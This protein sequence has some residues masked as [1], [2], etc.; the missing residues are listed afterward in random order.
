MTQ[1][2]PLDD[3]PYAAPLAPV[4]PPRGPSEAPPLS[5]LAWRLLA[6]IADYLLMLGLGW[7]LLTPPMI[8]L[9]YGLP[10]PFGTVTA[11]RA[12]GAAVTGPF[13][14]LLWI[15]Y[16]ASQE[17][18][19]RQSTLGKRL[20]RLRVVRVNNEPLSFGRAAYRSVVK[21]VGFVAFWVGCIIALFTPRRQAL[22]DLAAGTAVVRK[23]GQGLVAG[24]GR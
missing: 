17:S 21:L 9:G 6:F 8:L 16:F 20:F 1:I 10:V 22:H 5:S 7:G 11:A 23:A 19:G 15:L 18:S 24:E 3:N 2:D 14:L 13:A 4:E 12:L